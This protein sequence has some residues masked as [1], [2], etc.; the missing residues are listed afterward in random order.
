MRSCSARTHALLIVCGTTLSTTHAL[1]DTWDNSAGN[2]QWSTATNWADNTEP[3][4]TDTAIFPSTVPLNQSTILM[5]TTEFASSLT[6]NND[7]TLQGGQM[8]II[9]GGVNVAGGHTA[10]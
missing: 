4:T 7:Y 9:G 8:F 5:T 6:F 1:A 10:T 2:A 3:T